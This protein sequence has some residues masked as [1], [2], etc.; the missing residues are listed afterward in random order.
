L[1]SSCDDKEQS[2]NQIYEQ[3]TKKCGWEETQGDDGDDDT[4]EDGNSGDNDSD[5]EDQEDLVKKDGD[6]EDSSD[7]ESEDVVHFGVA[8]AGFS[9]VES[10]C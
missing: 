7:D 10:C 9:L 5:D 6:D 3:A 2:A 8:R 1:I 4:G